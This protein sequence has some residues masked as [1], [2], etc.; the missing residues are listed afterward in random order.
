M[1]LDAYFL[2]GSSFIRCKSE[3]ILVALCLKL[4][5]EHE[6]LFCSTGV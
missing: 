2:K 4:I 5:G 1:G 6:G 3:E